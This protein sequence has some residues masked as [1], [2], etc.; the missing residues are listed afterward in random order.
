MK[1]IHLKYE[2]DFVAING[3]FGV[4]QHWLQGKVPKFFEY[5]SCALAA[6]ANILYYEHGDFRR[7]Y[8]SK[9]NAIKILLEL[10]Q[11]IPP[12]PWGIP[13]IYFLKKPFIRYAAS[14]GI[15]FRYHSFSGPFREKEV[16]EFIIKGL[17]KD[18]PMLLL[19]WNHPNKDFHN[20][21]V[22]ITGIEW[23]TS[24]RITVSN[25]GK[26]KKYSLKEYLKG[27]TLYRELGFFDVLE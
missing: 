21:W 26:R 19:T 3:S 8:L 15:H 27:K 18:H 13:S 7:N 23:D 17:S 14:K 16:G 12:M 9:D 10:Y 22:T 4:S 24:Y 20:H 25:W 5:R 2:H 11:K 1:R 6:L